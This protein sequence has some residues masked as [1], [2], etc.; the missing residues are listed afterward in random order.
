MMI[1]KKRGG[2]GISK[3]EEKRNKKKDSLKFWKVPEFR[4]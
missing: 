2:V 3:K 1:A 4:I